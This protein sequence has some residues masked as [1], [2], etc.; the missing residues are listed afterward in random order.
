MDVQVRPVTP[1]EFELFVRA[2]ERAFGGQPRP[3]EL[4]GWRSVVEFERSLAVFD[5]P[6]IVGTTGA[7][8]ITVTVPGARVPMP[9]VTWV[10]VAPTHRRRGLLTMMMRRQLDDFHEAGEVIAGLWAS[11][12][13]IY[14]RFGYGLAAFGAELDILRSK[15][16]F[17]RPIS[18]PGSVRIEEDKEK[19]LE[20][21]V[22]IHERVARD[23]PGMWSR[24][25]ALWKENFADL[26]HWRDGYSAMHF[27]IYE[28]PDGPEGYAAY[29]FK[30]EWNHGISSS[31]LKVSEH[32]ATTVEAYAALWRFCFDHDLVNN[33][34][35]FGRSPDEPLLHMLGEPRALRLHKEDALW[36][37]LVDVSGALS[38]RRY[39][40]EGSVVFEVRDSFC[41]WN[42]GRYRLEAGPESASCEQT[43]DEPDLVL[44]AA[45]L[46][47]AY[48]G[49]S[50][51]RWLHR[52]GRVI[53]TS[54][55]ALAR[56]DDLF[57]WDP[58][59]WCP[60]VF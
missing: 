59:P 50:S 9:G 28:G 17:A 5:G 36:I 53:E 33:I 60:N 52:A 54:E 43:D 30:H 41:P 57:Q 1:D 12:G 29:R 37:R 55:G 6:A 27:A 15:T 2:I 47:A 23:R 46:S 48:L 11:E 31:T 58:P 10:G 44:E 40:A 25:P 32:M 20:I 7:F 42:D 3:E 56:A 34:T 8:S 22:P 39:S 14:Q 16:T 49:G 45:D 24:T 38:A 18:W 13:A 21:F 19:A 35:A 51:F 26:E 4:E